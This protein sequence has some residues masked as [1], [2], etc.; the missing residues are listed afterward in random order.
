MRRIHP[1]ETE[2]YRILRD[3]VD[4]SHLEPL[5]RAV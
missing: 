5:S 4:L 1:I 3:L 2:S